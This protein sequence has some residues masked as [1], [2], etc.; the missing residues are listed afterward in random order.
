VEVLDA[1]DVVKQGITITM[2]N[3]QVLGSTAQYLYQFVPDSSF[4][5]MRITL[6]STL[7]SVL[8][9]LRSYEVC[10]KAVAPPAP[11]GDT[12]L[13]C[14]GFP[15]TLQATAPLGSSISWYATDSA[16]VPL[17][18]GTAFTTPVLLADTTYYLETTVDSSGCISP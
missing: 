3:L 2:G 11:M 18:T 15:A 5:K 8:S 14:I 7:A 9:G 13:A 12:A 10:R 16:D 1:N 17:A 4:S 6:T